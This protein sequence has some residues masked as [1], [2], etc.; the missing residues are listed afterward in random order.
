M[1]K[2]LQAC[3]AFTEHLFDLPSEH[4]KLNPETGLIYRFFKFALVISNLHPAF[5]KIV[6]LSFYKRQELFDAVVGLHQ[7]G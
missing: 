7:P 3:L 1:K 6:F 2:G 5:L 4:I